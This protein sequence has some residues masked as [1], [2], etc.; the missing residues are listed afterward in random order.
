MS[1]NYLQQEIEALKEYVEKNGMTYEFYYRKAELL[2]AIGEYDQAISEF[3]KALDFHIDCA[4]IWFKIGECHLENNC[5][6]YALLSFAHSIRQLQQTNDI[7][8]IKAICQAI[9]QIDGIEER[10]LQFF[11]DLLDLK[12]YNFIFI[13][14]QAYENNTTNPE[15]GIANALQELGCYV[16]YIQIQDHTYGSDM[17]NMESGVCVYQISSQQNQLFALLGQLKQNKGDLVICTSLHSQF[18]VLHDYYFKEIVIFFSKT[19]IPADYEERLQTAYFAKANVSFDMTIFL[20]NYLI[21]NIYSS[22]YMHQGF[23][24]QNMR[25]ITEKNMS[26]TNDTQILCLNINQEMLYLLLD[27]SKYHPEYRFF[28]CM[29]DP[30][31][32]KTALPDCINI[33]E[34]DSNQLDNLKNTC[35]LGIVS[36]KE[37]R[38][39]GLVWDLVLHAIPVITSNINA[40]DSLEPFIYFAEEQ[41]QIETYIKE[42]VEEKRQITENQYINFICQHSWLHHAIKL[43]RIVEDRVLEDDKPGIVFNRIRNR[44]THIHHKTIDSQYANALCALTYDFMQFK[45]YML[46]NKKKLQG[47]AVS[48]NPQTMKQYELL[49]NVYHTID[50]TKKENDRKL[51][52]IVGYFGAGNFG[53]ELLLEIMLEKLKRE[54]VDIIVV[55]DNPLGVWKRHKVATLS[56][57]QTSAIE[58]VVKQCDLVIVGP[59]GVIQDTICV[60]YYKTLLISGVYGYLFPAKLANTYGKSVIFVGVGAEQ[61]TKIGARNFIFETLKMSPLLWLRD[62]NSKKCFVDM[63]LSDTIVYPD[64]SFLLDNHK[65]ESK[66][67][68]QKNGAKTLGVNLRWLHLDIEKL[69]EI[70][71]VIF[72]YINLG[73]NISLI[74][75]DMEEDK[76]VLHKIYQFIINTKG[77]KIRHRVKFVCSESNDT[78]IKTIS[79]IDYMIAMRLHIGLVA[80]QMGIPTIFLSYLDKVASIAQQLDMEPY[81]LQTEECSYEKLMELINGLVEHQQEV[82]ET[83][84][85]KSTELREKAQHAWKQVEKFLL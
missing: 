61:I 57:K 6:E 52:L 83:L 55:G 20:E 23:Y 85:I 45:Q 39:L 81:I 40:L 15:V 41:H 50:Y 12:Q 64:V 16:S 43:I 51:I 36:V 37:E 69:N 47:K 27:V 75:A 26:N 79:D 48:T 21:H 5:L 46:K 34:N 3:K 56:L 14:D 33:V 28:I 31:E 71:K 1:E 19:S 65:L 53:D 77:E 68:W 30:I 63:G 44:L 8:R 35:T 22:F 59:G 24:F 17:K 11:Y 7:D 54:N 82:K 76:T 18:N 73:W 32:N 2:Y 84:I 4:T 25:K 66:K 62:K 49:S 13:S 72:Q 80:A 67:K 10:S 78:I 42:V 29:S 60:E 70:V 38:D 58:E 9:E 74:C